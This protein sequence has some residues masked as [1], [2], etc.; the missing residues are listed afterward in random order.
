MFNF[1]KID[2]K[3]FHSRSGLLSTYQMI[4]DIAHDMI[5]YKLL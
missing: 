5:K 4:M 3:I 1:D 2:F